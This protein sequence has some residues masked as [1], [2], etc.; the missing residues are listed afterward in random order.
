MIHRAKLVTI[1]RVS[2]IFCRGIHF[3]NSAP[4]GGDAASSLRATVSQRIVIGQVPRGQ[5]RSTIPD[6]GRVFESVA[7]DRWA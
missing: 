5:E 3:M 1:I 4:S 6:D 7:S 2:Q